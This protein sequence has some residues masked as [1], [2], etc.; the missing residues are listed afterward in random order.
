LVSSLVFGESS[1]AIQDDRIAIVQSLS[2]TGALRV[3]GEFIKHFWSS[4]NILIPTPTWPNHNGVFNNSDLNIQRYRYY[5]PKT[6]A[7]DFDGMLEDIGAAEEGAVI[8]LHACA[9]NPTGVDPT[10]DQ[11]K[12]IAEVVKEKNHLV[13]FDAAY[14]GFASGDYDNDAFAI[15]YFLE[16]EITLLLAVSFAKNMVYLS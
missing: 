15:R 8:L 9:H 13:F 1:P 11:W 4:K 6:I 7:L 3:G 2:G 12:K 5:D 14:L 10:K 16:Q